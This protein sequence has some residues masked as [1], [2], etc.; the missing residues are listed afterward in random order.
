MFECIL[1]KAQTIDMY[2]DRPKHKTKLKDAQN[3]W[4]KEGG[5]AQLRCEE[6]GVVFVKEELMRKSFL[7][8]VAWPVCTFAWAAQQREVRTVRSTFDVDQCHQM[9]S[10]QN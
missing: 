9:M 7:A 3:L 6:I 8:R 4:E 2:P 10:E 1:F 5:L